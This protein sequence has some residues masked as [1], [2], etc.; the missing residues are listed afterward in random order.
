MVDIPGNDFN[1]EAD[2]VNNLTSGNLHN[3]GIRLCKYIIFIYLFLLISLYAL[4]WIR[5]IVTIIYGK[6]KYMIH[7]ILYTAT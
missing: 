3:C 6:L 4:H 2:I 1:M 7:I 5:R